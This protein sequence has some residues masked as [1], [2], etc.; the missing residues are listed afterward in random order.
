MEEKIKD[1]EVIAYKGIELDMSCKG[2]QYEVGKSYK[3]D[4]A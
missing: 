1:I 2:F 4:K 3:T